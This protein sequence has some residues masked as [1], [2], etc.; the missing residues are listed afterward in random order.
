MIVRKIREEEYLRTRQVFAI[1]FEQP[2]D[3]AAATPEALLQVKERPRERGEQYWQECWAAFNE[4]G[5]MMSFLRGAPAS[6]HFDTGTGTCTCIGAVSSLPQYRGRGAVAACFR[7]HLQDSYQA[8]VEFSYLYPFSTRFYRQFG[9]ELAAQAV[10]WTLDTASLPALLADPGEAVLSEEMSHFADMQTVYEQFASAYNMTFV[11]ER[12]DWLPRVS[13]NPA[14]DG[15][16]TYLWYNGAGE[17]KGLVTFEKEAL[18]SGGKQMVCTAFYYTDLEGLRGLLQHLRSYRSHFQQV[19]FSLP[20]P[21]VLETLLPEVVGCCRRELVFS[22][23]GRVVHVERALRLAQYRGTGEVCFRLTDPCI[24]E[25]NRVFRVTFAEGRC[26]Q[27]S[28]QGEP[29]LQL[30]VARFSRLLLGGCGWEEF[31]QEPFS[32]IFY[33]KKLFVC[34]F[35]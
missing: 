27:I 30:D 11:R 12:L 4:E 24:P 16:Y 31:P 6:V 17:P 7:Q 33:P 21:V 35:F 14:Q 10:E 15:K 32:Q 20:V 25:N 29:T 23:M 26:Q 19:R 8:G 18:P 1:A 9:Y 2:L 3:P 22:G 34:D 5:Q 28:D 13:S